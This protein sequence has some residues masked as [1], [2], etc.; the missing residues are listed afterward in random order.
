MGQRSAQVSLR[1]DKI[2]S[3]QGKNQI[4]I[5]IVEAGVL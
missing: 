2:L 3:R 4:Q 1:G 5:P